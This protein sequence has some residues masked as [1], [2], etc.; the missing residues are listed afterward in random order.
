MRGII[1]KQPYADAII[2]KIKE[3]EY[4]VYYLPGAYVDKPIYLLSQAKVL[5]VIKLT[6]IAKNTDGQRI[7]QYGIKVMEKFI[8]PLNYDH[9]NGAQ[10]Y[11]KEVKV[12]N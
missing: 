9:P 5:G 7:F 3:F 4:R 6:F 11:V 10:L 2:N 8:Q 12:R 1:I